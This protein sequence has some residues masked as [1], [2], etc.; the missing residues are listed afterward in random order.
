MVHT[1]LKRGRLYVGYLIS[2][3]SLLALTGRFVSA[4]LTTPVTS[5]LVLPAKLPCSR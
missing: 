5:F 3:G 1:R 2:L 4:F